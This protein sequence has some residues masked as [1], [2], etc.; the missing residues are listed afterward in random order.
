MRQLPRGRHRLSAEAVELDQRRRMLAAMCAAL[1]EHGYAQTTVAQVLEG[2]GVS[3]KTFYEQFADKDDCLLAAYEEAEASLWAAGEAA[4]EG[5]PRLVEAT[6]GRS[7]EGTPVDAWPR[8]VHAVAAAILDHVAADPATASL[9]TLEARAALPQIAE[10][11]RAVLD[12]VA[13]IL[14]AGNRARPHPS[15]L[16]PDTERRLLD[17]VVA[18]IGSYIVSGATGLLP[19]LAPQ[20]ADHLLLPYAEAPAS[21]VA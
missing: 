13:E 17:N 2:A 11:Q 12:R 1:A 20:L 16:P 5:V 9:L 6:R 19:D 18:L 8:R 14:R 15:D 3:R 21:E 10:R 4:G 7:G